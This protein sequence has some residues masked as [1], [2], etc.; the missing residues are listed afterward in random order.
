MLDEVAEVLAEHAPVIHALMD[1]AND[2]GSDASDTDGSDKEVPVPPPEPCERPVEVMS[3]QEKR[4]S[5]SALFAS[6]CYGT[7]ELLRVLELHMSG[8]WTLSRREEPAWDAIGR[9]TLVF[10][11]SQ[12]R[13]ECRSHRGNCRCF[14]PLSSEVPN[15]PQAE[16][17]LV[18]WLASGPY[19]RAEEHRAGAKSLYRRWQS[20]TSS[21]SASASSAK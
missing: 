9:I 2:E 11:D 7:D 16:A 8:S 13:G 3:L 18:A 19:V 14:L 10:G 21:A 17:A 4:K 12:L 15:V 6:D 20:Q 5:A 1:E